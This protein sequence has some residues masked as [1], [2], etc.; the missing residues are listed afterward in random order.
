MVTHQT[1]S[2]FDMV[3]PLILPDEQEVLGKSHSY[4]SLILM[5]FLHN[6]TAVFGII[7]LL[8]IIAAAT[9]AP[10]LVHET[11]TV[12]PAIDTHPEIGLINPSFAHPLGTDDV[13]RDEFARLLYGA[14]V[15]LLVG[16][17]SMAM[18]LFI[19]VLVGSLA[20]YYGGWI[21]NF[22]MRI[23]DVFLAVPLYLILFVLSAYFVAGGANSVNK[24]ILLIGLFSWAN[25][26]R[27]ARGEIMAIREREFI[28]AARAVDV[29]DFR[30]I[31]KHILPNAIGPLIVSATLLVGGN[32]ITESTLSFFNFGIQPP[33]ASWGNML[34][35][36]RDYLSSN[37]IL[38]WSPGLALLFTVLS[39]NLVGDGLR[40]ALDPHHTN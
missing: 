29:S 27:I 25:T 26:A 24:V 15:S 14:R 13:G 31:I 33:N 12:H 1:D 16:F 21:D 6:R 11:A 19:G 35:D 2:S 5:R 38:T 28:T 22:F 7:Y 34:A 37:P 23:T 3:D 40:D 32:I 10:I 18:A 4:F 8:L 17:V 20:G 36:S 39:F 30:M 9:F